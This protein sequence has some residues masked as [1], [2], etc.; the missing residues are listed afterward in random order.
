MA[1]HI[2]L[3]PAGELGQMREVF[4][5]QEVSP[6]EGAPFGMKRELLMSPLGLPCTPPPW[7]MIAGVNLD[8]GHIVWRQTIGTT[9]DLSP[10]PG[11]EL[12][13]PTLGGPIVTAGG[14]IFIGA[15]MDHY[16]RALDV[17]TG[18]ELWRSRLPS[19][20]N[21]TPMTY[22]WNGRQYV[23]IYAGGHARL[24]AALSDQLIAYALPD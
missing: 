11:L 2:Q 3:F 5:D 15:T 14:I 16:L 19:P 1:H 18:D 7:G 17:E 24:D 10:A 4:H 9:E 12:G 23:V 20:A 8:T 13:T 22:E 6:Q 21:A